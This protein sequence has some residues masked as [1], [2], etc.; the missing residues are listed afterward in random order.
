MKPVI[1]GKIVRRSGSVV[2]LGD[3]AETEIVAYNSFE[4][5]PC[6]WKGFVLDG[7]GMDAAIEELEIVIERIELSQ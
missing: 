7:K 3:D 6:R 2:L 5:W 4:A 1:D